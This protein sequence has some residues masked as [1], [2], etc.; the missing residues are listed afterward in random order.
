MVH[1]KL[2]KV[3]KVAYRLAVPPCSKIHPTFHVSLLKRHIRDGTPVS[4]TLP[5]FDNNGEF[6]WTL[7][8]VLD[9]AV[10]RKNKKSMTMWLVKWTGLSEDDATW[11]VARSMVSRF[12]CL[13][14]STLLGGGTC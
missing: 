10:Q 6:L 9:M 12:W 4:T 3:G 5:P 7:E 13:R 8:R 14:A 2:A 1:F 11:E